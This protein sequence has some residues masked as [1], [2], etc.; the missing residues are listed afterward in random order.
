MR[1]PGAATGVFT[2]MIGVCVLCVAAPVVVAVVG[3]VDETVG[4][5]VGVLG[6]A[7]AAAGVGVDGALVDSP[8]VRMEAAG[9]C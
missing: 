7:T 9:V 4:V 2:A 5:G 1:V 3:A 6:A 8:P